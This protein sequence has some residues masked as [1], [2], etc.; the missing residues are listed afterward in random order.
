MNR[1]IYNQ[2]LLKEDLLTRHHYENVYQIP[3][4]K[5]ITVT[6]SLQSSGFQRKNLPI[7]LLASTM[8]TGQKTKPVLTKQGNATFGI[9]KNDPVATKVTLRKQQALHFLDYLTTIVLPRVKNF[10]GL[11]RK[12]INPPKAFN[13]QM[14]N[15]L[16]F[17]QLEM[18]YE[19]FSHLGPINISLISNNI[20]PKGVESFWRCQGLPFS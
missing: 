12:N 10:E 18:A 14:N 8:I 11:K 1:I 20:Q 9:R 16:T 19:Q 13:F 15:P 17:P 2:K 6:L 3:K 4:L 5:K 7:L